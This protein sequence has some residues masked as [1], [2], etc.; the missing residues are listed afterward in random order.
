MRRYSLKSSLLV[1]VLLCVLPSTAINIWLLNKNF[2]LRRAQA[3]L[4]TLLLARQ[5]ASELDSQLAAIESA[6]KVLAS[7]PEL[8]SGDIQAFQARAQSALAGGKVYN[9]ILTD[10]HGRQVMNTL[11]PFGS[12][13]PTGGTPAQLAAVF[14]TGNTVLTNMFTGPVTQKSA[15]AMGVPV[16]VKGRIVYSLN[17]GLSPDRINEILGQQRLPRGWLI[18]ILDQSGTIVGR[19]RDADRYVGEKSV[20]ALRAALLEQVEK[21]LRVP[22]KEGNPAF[23]ALKPSQRW[24][25]GVAVG[26]EESVL[27]ADLQAMIWRLVLGTGFVVGVALLLA[28]GLASRILS[29]VRGIND[30][31]SAISRGQP[32]RM[33]AAQFREAEAVSGALLKA[34]QAMQQVTFQSR[35]DPLTLLPNRTMF[36]E[37]AE[38][39]LSLASRNH[40]G[41][42]VIAIDLDHF[43][44][45]NDTQGHAAGDAVLKEAAARIEQ[46][47]RSSDIAA[48]LGGDEFLVLLSETDPASALHTANRIVQALGQPYTSTTF[49]VSGSAGVALYPDDGLT[50]D[51]LIARAD[52]ALYEAKSAGRACALHAGSNLVSHA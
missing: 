14:S 3:E 4:D 2:E 50:M 45:V 30:A 6:L 8:Q 1:L 32:F 31:A 42:A 39:Q 29:M 37:F 26:L 49:P 27:Y 24:Q 22:T 25:W 11:K 12:S 18:A 5:V 40:Y 7:A 35:H 17:V 36:S 19:S 10:R 21:R 46:A 13:L 47:V 34:S 52:Q 28:L 51:V 23:T 9:Y 16:W 44:S 20:P 38:R 43:K 15:I 41:M 33:P 48:R